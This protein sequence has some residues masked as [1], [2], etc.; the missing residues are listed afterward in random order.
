M[1]CNNRVIYG[2]LGPSWVLI[3][4]A[5]H[6]RQN[7]FKIMNGGTGTT[8][9]KEKKQAKGKQGLGYSLRRPSVHVQTGKKI[10]GKK[11]AGRTAYCFF[12][13]VQ[14]GKQGLG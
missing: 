3:I 11:D 7:V 6:H 10:Q 8:M 13:H 4:M 1:V 12:L 2:V 9:E 5:T 14:K